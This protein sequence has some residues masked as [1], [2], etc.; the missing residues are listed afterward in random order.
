[1]RNEGWLMVMKCFKS[2]YKEALLPDALLEIE[3]FAGTKRKLP[4][5]RE[6]KPP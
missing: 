5:A 2:L 4:L 6:T 1:L 3:D